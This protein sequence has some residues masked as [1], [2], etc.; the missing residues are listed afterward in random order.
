MLNIEQVIRDHMFVICSQLIK[1]V[2]GKQLFNIIPHNSVIFFDL[3]NKFVLAL[4]CFGAF[5]AIIPIP[6]KSGQKDTTFGEVIIVR[7]AVL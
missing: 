5:R 2:F 6:S 3:R 7:V 1:P 4:I